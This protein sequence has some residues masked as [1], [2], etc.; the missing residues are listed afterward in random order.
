MR[1][2][3]NGLGRDRYIGPIVGHSRQA[4]CNQT[5]PTFQVRATNPL[6][7]K[8][9]Q[10]PP[11]TDFSAIRRQR[12]KGSNPLQEQTSCLKWLVAAGLHGSLQFKPAGAIDDTTNC[13]EQM[14]EPRSIILRS[15]RYNEFN[16]YRVSTAVLAM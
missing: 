7:C 13:D 3:G 5:S 8:T 1:R 15:T 2:V 10:R 12:G 6:W 4:D 16:L 11:P 9:S 14:T